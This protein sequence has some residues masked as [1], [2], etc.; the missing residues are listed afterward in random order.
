[1]S[2]K[3]SELQSGSESGSYSSDIWWTNTVYRGRALPWERVKL[4][5]W[6]QLQ[7]SFFPPFFKKF[8]RCPKL[9]IP[10]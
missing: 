6:W 5:L 1:M 9:P 4:A 7:A 2:R 3:V 8:C 10:P